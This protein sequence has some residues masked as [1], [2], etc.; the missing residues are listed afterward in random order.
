MKEFKTSI[1]F[2][3]LQHSKERCNGNKEPSKRRSPRSPETHD[4]RAK[5]RDKHEK[6]EKHLHLVVTDVESSKIPS[7]D[8]GISDETITTE[9]ITKPIE[10]ENVK[11]ELK[12]IKTALEE[13][14]IDD[15]SSNTKDT[16]NNFELILCKPSSSEEFS[17][18]DNKMG[19]NG[20][21]DHQVDVKNEDRRFDVSKLIPVSVTFTE[22]VRSACTTPILPSENIDLQ[23][24]EQQQH[25]QLLNSIIHSPAAEK[26]IESKNPNGIAMETHHSTDV[27]VNKVELPF[28][29]KCEIIE[30]VDQTQL[31]SFA[32]SNRINSEHLKAE[33]EPQPKLENDLQHN[34]S[35]PQVNDGMNSSDTHCM[36]ES[37][38][39][40]SPCMHNTSGS[41]SVNISTSCK[42][43]L[44]VEN[45]NNEQVIYVT[46]KKKKKKKKSLEKI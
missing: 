39:D 14:E 1:F 38:D 13:G 5:L 4:L 7:K 35:I 36:I 44:I 33:I 2:G 15:N 11:D 46:R 21:N 37:F 10:T 29:N 8:K 27:N 20:S 32:E 43:Y 16:E 24:Q 31:G 23:Q 18:I 17:V 3:F 42:N 22:E 45:E 12:S 28:V 30:T 9:Q 40:G 34:E 41:K 6:T 26:A 19:V 25:I